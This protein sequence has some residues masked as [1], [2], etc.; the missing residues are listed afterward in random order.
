V[1]STGVAASLAMGLAAA[2]VGVGVASVVVAGIDRS[3]ITAIR[4]RGL[5]G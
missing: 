5:R 2:I 1:T 3:I 4:P